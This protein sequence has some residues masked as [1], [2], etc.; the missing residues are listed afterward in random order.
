M[1]AA[2]FAPRIKSFFT[3]E[4]VFFLLLLL[5]ILLRFLFLDLKLFHHDEA[6]HSWFSWK[7]LTEGTWQY[8]PTYHGPVL[9]FLTAGMFW[10]F[11]SSDLVG[12]LLPAVFGTLIIPLIYWIYRLGYLNKNQ[13]LVAALFVAI[14]PDMVYFSRFLRHDIFMLFFTFLFVVALL[15]Y[16]ESSK[17][18]YAILAAV[19]VALALSL[20]EEMPIIALGI[21]LYF[22]YALWKK[23]FPLPSQWKRDLILGIFLIIV[24][25]ATLYSAGGTHIDT[26]T[27]KNFD[28]ATSGWYQA[29]DHWTAMHN[30]QRLGGPWF[31]YILFLILYELPIFILAIIGILQFILSDASLKNPVPLILSRIRGRKSDSDTGKPIHFLVTR[32]LEQIKKLPVQLDKNTEFTRFC[33]VWMLLTMAMYAYIGEKVP[34]LLIPQLLPMI[35]VAAHRLNYLKII[36]VCAGCIFLALLTWHV[37]FVPADVNEPIVQVQNS[38]ELRIVMN[39]IDASDKVVLASKD[40]WPLPWYYRGDKWKKF[41]FYGERKDEDTLLRQNPGVIIL[42][43]SESYDSLPGYDKKTYRLSYWFSY[44]DNEDRLPQFYFLRDGKVGSINIDVFT[45]NLTA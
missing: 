2:G 22:I 42:H 29:V 36:G 6:I 39:Q 10:I 43:D 21:G 12:R 32:S 3:F 45:R 19:S 30:E 18:R 31:Y 11:G 37:A 7:L 27:G 41:T 1:S 8:D 25:M 33:I 5:A 28:I 13:T 17:S 14:S 35:F 15:A 24:L 16:F 34:W 23:K 20:K 9:Y 38:E 40:Y 44:Y 4:R 26:L